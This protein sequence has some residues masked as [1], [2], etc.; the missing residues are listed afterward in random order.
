MAL[1]SAPAGLPTITIGGRVFTDLNNLIILQGQPG[2]N[3]HAT[4]RTC[5]GLAGYTPSGSK[6]FRALAVRAVSSTPGPVGT[7]LGY[8]NTD[9]G[10]NSASDP[11][12][13]VWLG[14]TATTAGFLGSEQF[15][16]SGSTN[17]TPVDF[18]VPN[19]KYPCMSGANVVLWV[20][21]YEV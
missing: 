8:G 18:T 20:F 10:A 11:A 4:L 7:H 19:G 5:N 16:A 2:A 17:E 13:V 14:G 15:G 1:S 3:G 6:A 12:G 9:V 21:G